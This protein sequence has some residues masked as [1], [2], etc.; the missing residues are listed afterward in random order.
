MDPEGNAVPA[1]EQG[2]LELTGPAVVPGYW[3]NPEATAS[4]MPG[5]RLR[6]GDV[7]ILDEQGWVYL[8][9]RLKDQI[10]VSGYKVWPREVEDTLY[11][12][13]AVL[14]VAVVGEPDEYRG[15][16]VVAYVSLAEGRTATPE[17]LIAF[18]GGGSRPTRRRARSTSSRSSPRPRPGRSAATCS[19]ARR[20]RGVVGRGA[21]TAA[22]CDRVLDG[23]VVLLAT[24]TVVYHACLLLRLPAS[25]ALGLEAVAL[26]AV[27]LVARRTGADPVPAPPT[28]TPTPPTPH[29]TPGPAAGHRQP[30]RVAV[31]VLAVAAPAAAGA[32]ALDAPWALVWVPW[33][34]A[35]LAGCWAAL[36]RLHADGPDARPA[37]PA[38][39]TSTGTAVLALAWALGLAVL[40]T[41][42]LR[43]NPDDLYYLNL[44]QWV[45]GHGTFPLRDTIFADLVY[46][47]SNWPPVASYDAL[48]GV[49]AHVL[50]LRAASVEYLAVPP[51]ATALSVLA[52]WRLLRCWRAR[53]VA[54][55]LSAALVFLLLDGGA[56]YG[57]PGNLF[58]TRLWQGKTI[59]LCLM[60]P[61][62]LVAA[63]R[64]VER[65][66]RRG[67]L[68]LVAVGAASVALSTSALF[69]VPVVA[70][71]AM[72]P[73]AVRSP[74]RALTGFA[75]MAGYP[76]AGAA[77]TVA[78]G[79]RSADTFGARRQYRFDGAWIG[80]EVFGTG[81]VGFVAVLAVLCA[82]LLVPHRAMRVTTTLL[83]AV[84][85]LVLVPGTT[86]LAYDL[87]GLGPTLWRLS[88][89][90]TVAALVGMGAVRVVGLLPTPRPRPG[91]SSPSPS[92]SGSA[93]RSGPRGRACGRRRSTGS[94]RGAASRPRTR[95]SPPPIRGT[96]CW[97]RT[98]SPSASR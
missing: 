67:T 79:G 31:R 6:A 73:L 76:L 16:V 34:V 17:E 95:S 93:R 24:W 33:L 50:G 45:A 82:A 72:A 96:S 1:G 86:R 7:A 27:V 11:A 60:V 89:G 41:C 48:V 28:P 39:G 61:L 10:N 49:V 42:L 62:L 37:R 68:W 53:H 56:S 43:P 47:M 63:A 55:V 88:W 57:T 36:A 78:V 83:A 97:P 85:G 38:D 74:R 81:P 14:E 54:W 94:G 52:L 4:T 35:S 2:E 15:E 19:G 21:V 59:L 23:V 77:V 3:N 30:G 87:T 25:W 20:R 69:L 29:P 13:P 70:L 9:D 32:M 71:A 40:A 26:A 66:G 46:P 75:A 84:L 98:R 91:R 58:L 80:H 44:S 65:P 51:L 22:R 90:C 5:G 8:V 92:R 64:H 18:A 12:H